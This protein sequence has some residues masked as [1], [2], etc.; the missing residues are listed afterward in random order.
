MP[1]DLLLSRPFDRKP[2][3]RKSLRIIVRGVICIREPK[4]VRIGS[5]ADGRQTLAA[6]FIGSV[7]LPIVMTSGK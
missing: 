5:R 7:P 1:L 6:V 2:L 4:P 3:R